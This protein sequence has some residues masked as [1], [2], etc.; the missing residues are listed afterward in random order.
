MNEQIANLPP[1]WPFVPLVQRN[2]SPSEAQAAPF[3]VPKISKK[4]LVLGGLCF[5]KRG[6]LVEHTRARE[7]E[8]LTGKQEAVTQDG[9]LQGSLSSQLKPGPSVS[10]LATPGAMVSFLYTSLTL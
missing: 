2:L 6:P 3:P 4:V 5:E 8:N 7:A 9:R 10:R 1:E